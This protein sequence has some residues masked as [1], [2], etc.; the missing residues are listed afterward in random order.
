MFFGGSIERT[1]QIYD[2]RVDVEGI[3]GVNAECK[4]LFC[5]SLHL[6]GGSSED[7]HVHIFEFGDMFHHWIFRQF[8]RLFTRHVAAHHT[9]AH[10]VARSFDSVESIFTNVAITHDGSANFLFHII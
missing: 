9:S 4:T 5:V 2:L 10:H 1:A 3:H 8:S 7:S 6:S